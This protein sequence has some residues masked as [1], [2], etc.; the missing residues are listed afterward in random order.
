MSA[1]QQNRRP[2]PQLPLE[3][4]GPFWADWITTAAEAASHRLTT[5]L[6]QCWQ[7]PQR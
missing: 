5:L 4:F 7:A 1:A 2:P 6:A 3:V